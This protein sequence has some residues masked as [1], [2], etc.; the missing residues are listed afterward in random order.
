MKSAKKKKYMIEYLDIDENYYIEN[1]EVKLHLR[2]DST[3]RSGTWDE[4]WRDVMK[5]INAAR[6]YDEEHNQGLQQ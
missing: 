1:D 4:M 6:K 5:I 2:E 3:G